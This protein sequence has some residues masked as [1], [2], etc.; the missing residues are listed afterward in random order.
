MNFKLGRLVPQLT[1]DSSSGLVMIAGATV[2]SGSADPTSTNPDEPTVGDFYHQT[3]SDSLF[4]YDGT[5]WTSVSGGGYANAA[6][7]STSTDGQILISTGPTTEATWQTLD[8]SGG[9]YTDAAA[10]STSADGQVLI[11]TGSTT[12]ATWQELPAEISSVTFARISASGE[13][14]ATATISD[15]SRVIVTDSQDG[16][17]LYTFRITATEV[18][19]YEADGRVDTLLPINLIHTVN[20]P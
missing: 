9:V 3:T 8:V 14:V 1:I 15:E 4:L 16:T 10:V 2:H 17:T 13:F 19:L 5:D 11:S 20:F 12:E 6:A 7:V 18:E